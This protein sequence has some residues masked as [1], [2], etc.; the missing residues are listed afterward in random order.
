M[1]KREINRILQGGKVR[2][3][4]RDVYMK[5]MNLLGMGEN[6]MLYKSVVYMYLQEQLKRGE[7]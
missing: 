7:P 3:R 5:Y 1:R 2:G 4:N 6:W